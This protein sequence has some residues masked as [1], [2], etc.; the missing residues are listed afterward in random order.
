[1][2]VVIL[3]YSNRKYAE[4][5]MSKLFNVYSKYLEF[6]INLQLIICLLFLKIYI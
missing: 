5:F 1:M 4:D 2:S 3:K 6:Q